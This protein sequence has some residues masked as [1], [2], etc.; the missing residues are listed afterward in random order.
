MILAWMLWGCMPPDD[1]S[2]QVYASSSLTDVMPKIGRE[3][4]E[5]TGIP[6]H[7]SFDASSRMARQLAYGAQADLYISADQAWMDWATE[8]GAI[9]AVTRRD[10]VGNGLA[11]VVPTNADRH[12]RNFDDLATYSTVAIPSENVPAG[13]YAREALK[14]LGVW[15]QI[16]PN[17]LSG[18]A[19][20]T[21]TGWVAAG[22][23]PVG[24][25]YRTEALAD[26]RVWP[27]LPIPEDSH[28][29]I[30]YPAAVTTRSRHPEDAEAFLNFFFGPGRVSFAEAG[31]EMI[32][33]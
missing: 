10:V 12:P 21:V 22:S 8:Q 9:D 32:D 20:R 3:W 16:E 7:F 17:V 26:K 27:V 18:D 29:P 4:T 15:E 5:R 19:A 1:G 2:L 13:R 30:V 25:V 33:L 11:I 23:V 6:I 28:T 31:F 24:V 14:N